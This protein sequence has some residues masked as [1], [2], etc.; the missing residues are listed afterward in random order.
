MAD[1]LSITASVA[2]VLTISIQ[3]CRFLGTFFSQISEAP[4]DAE[5]Y[6][7]FFRALIAAFCELQIICNDKTNTGGTLFPPDFKDR[8]ESC[9][10]DLEEM[11]TFVEGINYEMKG[12]KLKKTWTRISYVLFADERLK[13]FRIRLQIYQATFM[14]DLMTVNS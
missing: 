13:K 9:K 11:Q 14:L 3:T 4:A 5:Q 8:L 12:K 2:S 10:E 1:P 7:L 6:Q